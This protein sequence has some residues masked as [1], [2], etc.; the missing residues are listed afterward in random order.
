MR[1]FIAIDLPEEIRGELARWQR[2]L[3]PICPDA[4]WARPEGIHLTLKFLGEISADQVSQVTNSLKGFGPIEAFKVEVRGFGFFP[5][6]KR[7]RVLWA[8]VTAPDALAALA[9]RVEEAME[10]LGFAREQRDFNPH[11]TLARF[12]EPRPRPKLVEEVEKHR[13]ASLGSFEVRE[14]FLFES[15]LKKPSAEY[16][17]IAPIGDSF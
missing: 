3:A 5:D 14:F 16:R 6:A 9:T 13:E 17:R 2:T 11:L 8:G 4:R 1:T 15:V 7:P 10:K 12:K